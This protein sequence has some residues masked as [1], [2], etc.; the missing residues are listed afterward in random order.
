MEERLREWVRWRSNDRRDAL[1]IPDSSLKRKRIVLDSSVDALGGTAADA[2]KRR[3]TAN[4]DVRSHAS[5]PPAPPA[6][7]H[8]SI[9]TSTPHS[10]PQVAPSTAATAT[11][12]P[13]SQQ[14]PTM[15][16]NISTRQLLRLLNPFYHPD[17]GVSASTSEGSRP[18]VWAAC[19]GVGSWGVL[20]FA[21]FLRR[22]TISSQ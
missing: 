14:A 12:G 11:S 4:S 19:V 13:A 15:P 8:S 7:P 10:A 1:Q 16:P 17:M 9:F 2:E 20:M 21:L 22:L 6:S 18:S 3:T 5:R